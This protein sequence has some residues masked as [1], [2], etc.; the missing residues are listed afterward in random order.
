MEPDPREGR[1]SKELEEEDGNI[2]EKKKENIILET[3]ISLSLA[4]DNEYG[5]NEVPKN[6][7]TKAPSKGR[8]ILP[9]MRANVDKKQ[10][11]ANWRS[12]LGPY[13]FLLKLGPDGQRG[14]RRYNGLEKVLPERSK[15]VGIGTG[16]TLGSAVILIW[17]DFR[18][19]L[20]KILLI[21]DAIMDYRIGISIQDQEG[22]LGN[23]TFKHFC[24]YS[25]SKVIKVK[26]SE[27]VI[28]PARTVN[29]ISVKD[30]LAEGIDYRF[31]AVITHAQID[32]NMLIGEA[33]SVSFEAQ[34][35]DT[36]EMIDWEDLISEK[37]N[38]ASV[39]REMGTSPQ[40][41]IKDNERFDLNNGVQKREAE[42]VKAFTSGI[43]SLRPPRSISEE[44]VKV[45]MEGSK[46]RMSGERF[47][48]EDDHEQAPE[49]PSR[50]PDSELSICEEIMD[51]KSSQPL[52]LLSEFNDSF[53]KGSTIG[54]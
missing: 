24:G 36:R 16:Q 43:E 17:I 41:V 31:G 46:K 44:K 21:L 22:A 48:S 49:A 10:T 14:F 50:S 27:E 3:D 51:E 47:P 13:G 40:S 8:K 42:E 9:P 38:G 15:L 7:E 33:H 6:T 26:S 28:I 12:T 4:I 32:K 39:N 34:V 45:M 29:A 1:G 11:G 2:V 53:T 23:L 54:K 20:A 30:S 37:P 19:F 5:L 52:N 25:A 18:D 35:S